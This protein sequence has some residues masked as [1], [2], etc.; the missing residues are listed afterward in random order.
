MLVIE[1]LHNMHT[2]KWLLAV[3]CSYLSSR[4]MLLKYQTKVSSPRD[5]PGGFGQGVWLGGLLFIVKFNG[6]CLRPP[7]PRPISRN[8]SMQVKYIDDASQAAS[9]NLKKSL[10]P[11][12]QERIRPLNSHERTM[13]VLKPE[14]NI[15]QQELDRFHR[16]VTDNKFVISKKKCYTMV[17]SRSRSY[18]FPPEFSIGDSDLLDEKRRQPYLGLKFRLAFD[19]ILKSSTW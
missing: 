16:F 12:P 17:F 15:V 1:D 2:P 4:S 9:I 11:D 19:G 14:D 10:M 8:S 7:I 18:D 6:A 3:I 13:M 5:L